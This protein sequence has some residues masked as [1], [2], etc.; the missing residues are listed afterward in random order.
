MPLPYCTYIL[1]SLKDK[2]FYIGFTTNLLRR[3]HEH[4]NGESKSTASRRPFKL[5]YLEFHISKKDAMRREHYFKTNPGK[6]TLKLMLR[7]SMKSLRETC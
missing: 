5:I 6:K 4:A 2:N 3:M 7:E 1:I